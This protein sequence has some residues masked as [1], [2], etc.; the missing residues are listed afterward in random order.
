VSQPLEITIA[1][2]R[3][4]DIFLARYSRLRKWA[5]QLTRNDRELSEDLVQDA[6]VHFTLARPDL[7]L[8]Q[9]PDG[10]LY[11]MLRNLNASHL[12]RTRRLQS[13]ALTIIEYDSA[14]VGLR[15]TDPR[16]MVRIH[17]EL[18]ACCDYACMRKE[19]SKMGSVLILRFLHGYYPREIA[20]L[21]K[22]SR[23]AVEERLRVARNEARQY[24][25]DPSSLRF[26]RENNG[27]HKVATQTQ[28]AL[29]LTADEL[30]HELRNMIFDARSGECLPSALLAG[31]YD[32]P[33]S[34]APD[35]AT[36]AHVVSCPQC[37]D[38]INASLGLAP[39]SERYPTD[40]LEKETRSQ[41]GGDDGGDG[42]NGSGTGSEDFY[43]R[44]RR[45]VR[46]VSE[47]RP[48]EL[49]ISVNGQLL[50]AQKI[51]ARFN[52]QT[53]NLQSGGRIDFIEVISE[54]EVC[55][56]FMSFS[57]DLNDQLLSGTE[58]RLARVELSD[59]R[60]LEAKVRFDGSTPLVQVVYRDPLMITE[61]A[62]QSDFA[63]EIVPLRQVAADSLP[64]KSETDYA[65]RKYWT[66]LRGSAVERLLLSIFDPSLWL[67]PVTASAAVA[68]ILI[69]ALLFVRLHVPT[70][71]AAELLRQ[72]AS[73]EEAISGNP[74]FVLH[75]TLHLEERGKGS[76]IARRRIE[77]WQSAARSVKLRRVYDEQNKLVAGVWLNASGASVV[78]RRSAAPEQ[79]AQPLE[80][81]QALAS[82]E[83]WLIDLSAKDFSALVGSTERAQVDEASGTYTLSYSSE[84]ADSTLLSATL[85]LNR[86]D[87]RAIHQRLVVRRGGEINEYDFAEGA[88]EQL[89]FAQVAPNVFEPDAVFS[90]PA[91][92]NTEGRSRPDN[93]LPTAASKTR[94]P[95]VAA[96][97]ELEVEVTYLLNR[98]KADLG[99]QVSLTRTTV[100]ALR[101]EALVETAGRKEEVL[102]A[103]R[104]VS[105]N[106]A[107][108]L[109]VNTVK[110]AM[111]RRGKEAQAG[112]QVTR[113]IDV[114]SSRIPADEE[115]RRYFA[116]RYVG[117][118]QID[119]AIRQFAAR[120]MGHSRQALL[121]ASA[122]KRLAGRFSAAEISALSPA[123]RRK[124]LEMIADHAGT[125]QREVVAL[126]VE[127]SPIFSGGNS[128]GGGAPG[129]VSEGTLSQTAEH[130]LQL[131]YGHDEAVRSAFTISST[132]GTAAR[133]KSA[134][135]WRS[136]R[137]T[138][139]LAAAIQSINR[140]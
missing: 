75:R 133:L 41:G 10:Y 128:A 9:N 29:A 97:T 46:E 45:R 111:T 54:Q 63:Q 13:R 36:L 132:G 110:E 136:L 47:H 20:L 57:D 74:D 34:A 60:T 69:A 15:A 53:L 96:S 2:E 117:D 6:F 8:V 43:L 14:T 56:L 55:L 123:A 92:V 140:N 40:T 87:L 77:L 48:L 59:E 73:R 112:Q 83:F 130:L 65:P 124:W 101:V 98:I 108:I 27:R 86:S 99:E 137:S 89:P 115:L 26:I 103:L 4:E 120:A 109:E 122:L 7:S 126:R 24:L 33:D 91:A 50:A 64:A 80:S 105:N 116:P 3:H 31:L 88:Y 94:S 37:M 113:E 135:F 22:C 28:S 125:L 49:A 104:P 58:E 114:Q 23:E 66:Q 35:C 138:E 107:V 81:R 129:T 62:A 44:A 78:Y 134:Q 119:A 1:P 121:H 5:L 85:K 79:T 102:R 127:L 72:S 25:K 30:M 95:S 67:R 131:S 139:E 71:S 16:N 11:S 93:A 32:G 118:D 39:L 90:L 12:R 21:M 17:D 19:S 100:G 82:G 42:M 106:P 68:L 61:A 18:W 76:V 38:L 52:E 70:A 51:G 84:S